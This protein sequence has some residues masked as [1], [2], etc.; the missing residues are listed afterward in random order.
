MGKLLSRWVLGVVL[1]WSV[2]ALAEP[3]FHNPLVK[4]R[5]DPQVSLQADGYYY[6]TATVPEYDRIELRRTRDLDALSTAETKTVWTKHA[7]GPMSFHIWAPELHRIDGKW[8]IYF[9][10]GRADAHWDIRLYVLENSSPNPLE[11]TWTEKGQLK[12]EWE[13]F[14]LDATT[15][16]HNGQRYLVWTQRRPEPELKATNI[17]IAKMDTPTSI[18]GTPVMLS[19]PNYAWEKVKFEV[20][21]APAVLVRNGK[22]FITFSASATDASYSIGLLSADAKADLL[23]PASWKK[24]PEP[25]FKTSEKSGQYGPGHNSFTTTP[26]GKTDILVYHARNYRDIVGDSLYDPNRHTRAQVIHWRADGMPDFGE[27]LPDS[28]K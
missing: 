7:S 4:Q 8:Y 10:A 13:T 17:Y 1:C 26:D 15:F 2:Q 23:N 21:E 3:V 11:G 12:T 28:T 24:S 9:T 5:A 22:V 25:V 19:T 14:S 27:P 16:A 20:N 18:T 6:F